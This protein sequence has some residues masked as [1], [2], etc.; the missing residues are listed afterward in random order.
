MHATIASSNTNKRQA[1]QTL[2]VLVLHSIPM[3]AFSVSKAILRPLLNVLDTNLA[4]FCRIPAKCGSHTEDTPVNSQCQCVSSPYN[5]MA[6]NLNTQ[7]NDT[8][9]VSTTKPRGY[10]CRLLYRLPGIVWQR[11]PDLSTHV[12]KKIL[13]SWRHRRISFSMEPS[14]LKHTT[15]SPNSSHAKGVLH[16]LARRASCTAGCTLS[17][18]PTAKMQPKQEPATTCA[19]V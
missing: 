10:S 7:H 19:A 5:L 13:C 17:F 18:H 9:D 2:T 1:L 12:L 8:Q 6:H 14:T 16:M 4:L 15:A 11:L 3:K